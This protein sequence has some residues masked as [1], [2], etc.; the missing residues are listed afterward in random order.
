M[1]KN[2]SQK[3]DE[4]FLDALIGDTG[5]AGV[6]SMFN[7]G[8]TRQA[9]LAQ[10]LFLKD[11]IGDAVASLQAGLKGGYIDPTITGGTT[12]AALG[13]SGPQE[14]PPAEP[15]SK[16]PAGKPAAPQT[17]YMGKIAPNARAA[18]KPA[19]PANPLAA[20]T[21]PKR[22]VTAKPN[23]KPVPGGIT[24][25][26]IGMNMKEDTYHKLNALFESIMEATGG[27]SISA[28][29]TNWFDK[30][31]GGVDW[32]TNKA[33]IQP[34]IQNIEDTYKTDKGY[35]AIRKLANAAFALAKSSK[36]TPD[37][38]KDIKTPA[39]AA[40]AASNDV[41]KIKSALDNLAKTNPQEYNNLIKTLR[42]AS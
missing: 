29:M 31:M 12:A 34:L 6:R 27:Q 41:T 40:A 19:A 24:K 35:A 33:V 3:V 36:V 5:A 18:T 2:K 17:Q 13:S 16:S 15:A 11:F 28:Y 38:A 20:P 8:M 23:P 39:P 42:L 30:Y 9:Q 32:E 26:G 1:K 14:N 37:G 22:T 7:K 10:D 4:G 21:L 25:G